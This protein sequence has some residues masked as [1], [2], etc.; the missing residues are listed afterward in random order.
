MADYSGYFLKGL[1][2]G[3]Q[4]GVNL[5]T[6]IQEMKWQKA[7]RKKLAEEQEKYKEGMSTINSIIK[8]CGADGVYSEDDELKIMTSFWAS[9]PEVQAVYQDAVN[10]IQTMNK[11]K[12]EED[13]QWLK[14][15]LEQAEGLDWKNAQGIFDYTNQ[16]ITTEKGKNY[17]TAYENIAKRR[18]EALQAQPKVE[19]FPTAGG[20]TEAYPGA[21]VRYTEKGYV[22]EIAE[23]KGATMADE[24][25]AINILKVFVNASRETFE[26]KKAEL[27]QSKG[28]D[29]SA[30]SQD[31]LRESGS[32]LANLY[33]TPSEV[34]ANVKAPEGLTIVPSR[35]SKT[36]KY[37][38]T[39]QKKTTTP[40]PGTTPIAFQTLQNIKD[41]FKSV[42]TRAEYD[43]ALASYNASKEAKAS[44]WTP[45]LFENQLTDLIKRVETAIW[46]DFVNKD[47]KLKDKN[48]IDKDS[49]LSIWELYNTRLQ[50]YLKMIEEA[51]NAGIDVSQFQ[52]FIPYKSS[53]FMGMGNM[54][55]TAES[56]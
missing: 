46:A 48:T 9:I 45:P 30:Y 3:L 8:Q 12:F 25:S 54:S 21:G 6:Q 33:N 29:L 16:W 18:S 20:V 35:D 17:F 11:R 4:T 49:G 19:M 56:W 43:E 32:E 53:G 10:S 1:G 36:G 40:T 50:Y 27:E 55:V 28:L 15:T 39:F 37:Y 31:V 14:L 52:A 38:A 5:G 44:D 13:M 26:K 34:V 23:A 24:K 47:G 2:Q 42:K 22:P 41:S 51:R 7:Q